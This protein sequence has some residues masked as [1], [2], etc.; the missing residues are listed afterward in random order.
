MR[1]L[2]EKEEEGFAI[3]WIAK[4][5]VTLLLI[6]LLVILTP[7]TGLAAPEGWRNV[8]PNLSQEFD[9]EKRQKAMQEGLEKRLYLIE[10]PNG[11]PCAVLYERDTYGASAGLDCDWGF[12]QRNNSKPDTGAAQ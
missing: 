8:L 6:M 12:R 2:N 1:L 9:A 10:A 7:S 4:T 3:L 11:M 5:W